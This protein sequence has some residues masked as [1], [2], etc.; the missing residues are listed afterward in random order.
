VLQ[1]LFWLVTCALTGL[2]LAA[3]FNGAL[4]TSSKRVT[5]TQMY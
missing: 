1:P 3:P 4:L 5:N 2:T